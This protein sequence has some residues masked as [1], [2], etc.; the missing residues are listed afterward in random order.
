M[1]AF[2]Y[3]AFGMLEQSVEF[4]VNAV[5]DGSQIFGIIHKINI[6]YVD[7]EQLAFVVGVYPGFISLVKPAQ[8][9]D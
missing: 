2:F 3:S 1:A 4:C 8:V 5:E 9:I 7:D 6:V